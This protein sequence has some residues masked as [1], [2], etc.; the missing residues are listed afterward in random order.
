MD[1]QNRCCTRSLANSAVVVVELMK[2]LLG[3]KIDSKTRRKRKMNSDVESH[4]T[5]LNTAVSSK[6][7]GYAFDGLV[8]EKRD[9]ACGGVGRSPWSKSPPKRTY[10]SR[11][12]RLC[13]SSGDCRILSVCSHWGDL[14][15]RLENLVTERVLVVQR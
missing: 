12:S 5:R 2:L 7:N 13:D 11:L 15:P 8:G 14:H 3:F 9:R 10:P 4:T 6:A 1:G